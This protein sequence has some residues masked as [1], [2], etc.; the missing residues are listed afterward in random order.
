MPAPTELEIVGPVAPERA[1]LLSDDALTLVARL[2]RELGPRLR[3]DARS[4]ST[5][6]SE[7][8]LALR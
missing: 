5:V 6:V 2:Q 3:H 8:A 4:I 7:A 1:H